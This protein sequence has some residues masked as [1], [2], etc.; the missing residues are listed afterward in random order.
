M[1]KKFK[2]AM[3][4]LGI[5]HQTSIAYHP[6]CQGLM[7]CSHQTLKTALTKLGETGSPDWEENLPYALFA[8]CQAHSETKGY[9]P[10]KLLYTHSTPRPLDI[11]YEAWEDPSKASWVKELPDIQWCKVV[12]RVKWIKRLRNEVLN[13]ET[14]FWYSAW[15]SGGL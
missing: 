11:L 14:K 12:R 9:S 7:E 15:E 6:E 1:A 2:E 4:C 8:L 3:D 5:R 13:W 10:F